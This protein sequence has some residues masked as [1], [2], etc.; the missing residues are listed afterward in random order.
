MRYRVTLLLDL[1]TV[2]EP[3]E[4]ELGDDV[5]VHRAFGKLAGEL[6]DRSVTMFG[7]NVFPLEATAVGVRLERIDA[8]GRKLTR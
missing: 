4:L 3:V 2:S 1:R 5:T 6:K 8:K 7:E